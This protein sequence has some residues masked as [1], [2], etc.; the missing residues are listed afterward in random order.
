MKKHLLSGALVGGVFGIVTAWIAMSDA[1]TAGG[2]V[3]LAG[4]VDGIMAG[5]GIG[6]LI[7]IN[8]A[9]GSVA[10]MEEAGA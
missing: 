8:V 1:V 3:A 4:I 7:G 10:E 2:V 5:L 9:E 6:W